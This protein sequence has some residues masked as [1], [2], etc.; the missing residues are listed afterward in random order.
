MTVPFDDTCA[1]CGRDIPSDQSRL[2][3]ICYG[4]VDWGRDG[5]LQ[6]QLE[7]QNE[8]AAQQQERADEAE[9]QAELEKGYD[10]G[11]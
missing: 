6:A 2:C 3:S 1:G 11:I 7:M 4:D 8:A 10:P 5:Y 9:A